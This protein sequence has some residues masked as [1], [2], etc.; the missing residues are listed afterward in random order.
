MTVQ[1]VKDASQLLA[2]AITKL[3]QSFESQTGCVIHSLPVTPATSTTPAVVHVK[4]QI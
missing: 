2:Q 1:E 3:T 4:V